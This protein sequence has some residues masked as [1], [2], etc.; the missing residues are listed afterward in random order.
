MVG[1]PDSGKATLFDGLT[2]G[3]PMKPEPLLKCELTAWRRVPARESTLAPVRRETNSWKWTAFMFGYLVASAHLA[4]MATCWI[5]VG[6]GLWLL[7]SP[8]F[9]GLLGFDGRVPL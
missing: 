6:A 4:A 5:A 1:T 3:P 7:R 8:L 2:V 9:S